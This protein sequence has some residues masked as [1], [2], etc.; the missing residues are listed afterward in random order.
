MLYDP[1]ISIVADARALCA[2]VRPR[3]LHDPTEGGLATALQELAAAAN[4]TIRVEQPAIHI[5]DETRAVCDA[6]A[7]NP[8]GLL[9]S[10]ALLAIVSP[11]DAARFASSRAESDTYWNAIATVEA[12]P[13]RVILG[14]EHP[15]IPFPTFAR[16]ELA[17]FFD[18]A[19]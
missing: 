6:L 3:L 13:A 9:A 12:G 11:D 17:R 1:G 4:A 14:D 15:A 7:L 16:D 8:L 10:G 18:G 2:E 5:Y 19:N